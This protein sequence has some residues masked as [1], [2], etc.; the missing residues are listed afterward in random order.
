MKY[1]LKSINIDKNNE[2]WHLVSQDRATGYYKT[3]QQWIK[4][5][6]GDPGNALFLSA[7]ATQEDITTQVVKSIMSANEEL[8]ERQEGETLPDEE[9]FK[10]VTL[11]TLDTSGTQG[12]LKIR[13]IFKTEADSDDVYL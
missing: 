13:I 10:D 3:L 12:K 9:K 5:F 1:D 2:I 11:K 6:Y 7:N 4:Y 8:L